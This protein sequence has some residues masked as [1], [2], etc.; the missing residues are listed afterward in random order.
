MSF[1]HSATTEQGV[2]ILGLSG[3]IDSATAA[4]FEAAAAA[5]CGG[6]GDRVVLDFAALD[7]ISSAGLR[8]VLQAAKRAKQNQ[9]RLL[10]CGMSAN[11]REVFEISGFLKIIDSVADRPSALQLLAS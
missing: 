11:V 5:L 4:Q 9:A 6:S 2:Q 8:V 7:Y 3:R 1:G 10:L